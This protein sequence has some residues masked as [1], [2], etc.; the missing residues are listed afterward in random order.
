MG[1]ALV[2][3]QSGVLLRLAFAHGGTTCSRR[4]VGS[5]VGRHPA[6]TCLLARVVTP[7]W[8]GR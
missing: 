8:A 5:K 4:T 6:G 3:L 7:S 2:I 1:W